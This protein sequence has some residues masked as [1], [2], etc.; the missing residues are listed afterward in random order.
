M[1]FGQGVSLIGNIYGPDIKVS[2]LFLKPISLQYFNIS[3][4]PI[5]FMKLILGRKNPEKAFATLL[6][7]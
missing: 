7:L 6:K 5:V 3:L 2:I 1:S 4:K